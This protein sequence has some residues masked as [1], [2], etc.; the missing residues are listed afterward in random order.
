MSLN[1]YAKRT[2][3]SQEKIVEALRAAG[4]Q[5]YIIGKP[6]D[7]LVRYFSRSY[8]HYLWT[9]ME[10]KSPYG[11]KNPKARVDKRQTEQIKFLND[12]GTQIVLTPDQALRIVGAI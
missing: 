12:S 10:C 9:T 1:R 3:T 4:C 2:D 8:G 5:V 11:K 7:L 6:C